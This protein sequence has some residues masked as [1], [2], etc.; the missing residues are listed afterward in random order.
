MR[1]RI[2]SL[3]LA[4][5][6]GFSLVSAQAESPD[7][8]AAEVASA[9]EN[10][11]LPRALIGEDL[12][13]GLTQ[14]ELS[15]LAVRLFE[16]FWQTQELPEKTPYAA[17]EGH[18][19]QSEIEKA[20]GLGFLPDADGEYD[21]DA[22]VTR[23]QAALILCRVLKAWLYEDWTP[24]TDEEYVLCRE[25]KECFRDDPAIDGGARDS[26]YF[27]ASA[28]LMPGMSGALFCPEDAVSRAAAVA[29]AN[30]LLLMYREDPGRE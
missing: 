9:L 1:K 27:L 17:V 24:G 26:V 18:A 3:L 10:N 28:G 20:Y 23:Q 11:I 14:A 15:A 12:T 19:L 13:C 2:L 6:L 25:V 4:L 5:F 29:A 22:L 7:S 8:T 16:E 30:R 21:P